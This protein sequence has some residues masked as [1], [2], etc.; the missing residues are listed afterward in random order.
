V[1]HLLDIHAWIQ[2][3]LGEPLPPL[4]ETTLTEH[5]DISLWDAAIVER[6][7]TM[8][9]AGFHQDPAD[10]TDRRHRARPPVAP[11]FRRLTHPP[12][13]KSPVALAHLPELI[14]P[15]ATREMGETPP[16]YPA[17]RNPCRRPPTW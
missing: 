11:D 3:A 5:A 1:T 16:A 4:V 10:P 15:T 2:R 12:V 13:R 8:E 14:A 17:P 6:L 9:A 7:T